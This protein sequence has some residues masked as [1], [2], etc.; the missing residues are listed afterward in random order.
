M[1]IEYD[2]ALCNKYPKI[3]A[4][5]Y[6]T[7]QKTAMCWGFE[8]GDGWYLLLD[9]LCSHLQWDINHNNQPQIVASQV[10][11]K[12]GT[13]RFYTEGSTEKQDGAISLAELLSGKICEVCGNP[14]S[15]NEGIDDSW[16]RTRCKEHTK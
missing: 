14:G 16:L 1:K 12:Y 6:A 11:E 3:F 4:N 9:T 2:N 7:V 10:K 15:T 5:R 8:C 13:L